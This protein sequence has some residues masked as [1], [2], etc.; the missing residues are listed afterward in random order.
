MKSFVFIRCRLIRRASSFGITTVAELPMISYDRASFLAT[1]V[2]F[3][4]EL[5][6]GP[7]FLNALFSFTCDLRS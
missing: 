7:L 1:P 4:F 3:F 2:S 5:L 6:G